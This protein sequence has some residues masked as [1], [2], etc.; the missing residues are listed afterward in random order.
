MINKFTLLQADSEWASIKKFIENA[1]ETKVS[2]AKQKW[3][4]VSFLVFKLN[5]TPGP[6]DISLNCI[7]LVLVRVRFIYFLYLDI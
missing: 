6:K 1:S 5:P 4:K 2:E 7:T 3:Q